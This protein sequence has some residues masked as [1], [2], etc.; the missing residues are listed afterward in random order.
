MD[1]VTPAD[2]R[3]HVLVLS[4]SAELYGSD[5]ALLSAL[6]EVI[7]AFRVTIVF[8]AP[9]PLIDAATRLGARCWTFD[10]FALRRRNLSPTRML[11]WI[12]R[13]RAAHRKVRE[14]H[15]VDPFDLVY[16]N[17]LAVGLGPRVARALR[18]PLV[19]HAHECPLSPRALT[20]LLLKSLTGRTEL[21]ICNSAYTRSLIAGFEPRLDARAVVVP[22]GIEIPLEP[23]ASGSA[24]R[25]LGA[26]PPASGS[27]P[28]CITLVGRIHPKKGHGDAFA[29]LELATREGRDWTIDCFGDA[30]DEHAALYAEL[31]AFVQEHGLESRVRW[32][33]FEAGDARYANFDVAIVPSVVP[34]EFSL[35]C[36]EAQAMNLPVVATGPGGPSEVLADGET[37][38]VVPPRDPRALFDALARLDDDRDSARAMG[39]AGRLRTVE[40]FARDRYAADVRDALLRCVTP[41]PAILV[42]TPSAELYGSDRSLLSALPQLTT[43]FDVVI[44][45]PSDGPSVARARALGARVEILGDFALRRRSLRPAGVVPWLVRYL[46]AYRRVGRM[47][48]RHPFV[49]V[50]S[51][52]L[53]AGLGPAIRLRYRLPHVVHARECPLEP[54]WVTNALLWSVERTTD[55]VICN[56]GYTESLVQQFRPRLSGRTAVVHNGINLPR[57][58]TVNPVRASGPLRI[59]CVGRIHPKK[60]QGVLLEAAGMA[61]RD[62]REW[63]IDF[64]G[65]ALPE[66]RELLREYEARARRLGIAESVHWHGFVDGDRRYSHADVAVVPSVFPEE[67][68]LVCVEAQA[69]RLP[70]VAT[71]PGGP[72]EILVDGETGHIVAPG[73]ADALYAALAHLDDDREHAREFGDRGRLRMVDLFTR[74]RYAQRVGAHLRSVFLDGADS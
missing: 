4:P 66:H 32:R 37:G 61:H 55:L 58:P 53:A 70:V 52:T 21:L 69:A 33:G 23:P 24:P 7:E 34:E 36:A 19:V 11:S 10:D 59:T 54:R 60:G 50:Y 73:D 74:E 39:R 47:H 41:R 25:E 16:Q 72:S 44:A 22:N 51:N 9:G 17:T 64:F 45:V 68:S 14:L 12:R 63:T 46:R 57:A 26:Q 13:V 1:R 28:L 15:R 43:D 56:S 29:A 35:V 31:R 6:P 40:R 38:F 20:V 48:R 2:T 27:Q 62:G 3:P 18:V 8:A 67:F 30:L 42:L 5:R 49:G 71:G 65:D